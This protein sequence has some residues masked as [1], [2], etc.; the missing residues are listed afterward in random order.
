MPTR[1]LACISVASYS[2]PAARRLV[3]YLWLFSAIN[4]RVITAPSGDSR[5]GEQGKH[6]GLFLIYG[7]I[8]GTASQLDILR[9]QH[10]MGINRHHRVGRRDVES[11]F[12]RGRH[13]FEIELK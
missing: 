10:R 6:A 3:P 7:F 2:S 12:L 8:A 9:H 5:G 1:T 4:L 11:N 13:G